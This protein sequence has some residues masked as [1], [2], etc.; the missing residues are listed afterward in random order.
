MDNDIN[1]GYLDILKQMVEIRQ[2]IREEHIEG[3]EVT[4]EQAAE[5]WPKFAEE[6][7]VLLEQCIGKEMDF[8]KLVYMFRLKTLVDEG[9]VSEYDAS[10]VH[11]KMVYDSYIKK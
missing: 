2:F 4:I 3:R 1:Q 8:N 9:K 11:G 7:K 10:V 6:R 5:K